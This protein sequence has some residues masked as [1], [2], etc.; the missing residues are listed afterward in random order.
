MLWADADVQ[1]YLY[2]DAVDFRLGIN[3]QWLQNIARNFRISL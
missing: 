1:V 2:S 3:D